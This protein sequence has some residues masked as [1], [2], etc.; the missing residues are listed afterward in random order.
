MSARSA[1]IVAAIVASAALALPA[2]A[3]SIAGEPYQITYQSTT[4]ELGVTADGVP[5]RTLLDKITKITGIAFQVAPGVNPLITRSVPPMPAERAIKQLLGKGSN[6]VMI[7]T[8]TNTDGEERVS[9]TEVR[10]LE[11]GLGA[12]GAAAVRAVVAPPAAGVPQVSP[13]ELAARRAEKEAKRAE[14]E[15]AKADKQQSRGNRGGSRGTRGNA[16]TDPPAPGVAPGQPGEP[17]GAIAAPAGA[18]TTGRRR[19]R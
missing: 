4:G 14:K 7:F 18:T 6:S 19:G 13:E 12:G 1:A 3:E 15:Q 17:N 9:L 5:L 2:A 8:K 10:V 11:G 16:A